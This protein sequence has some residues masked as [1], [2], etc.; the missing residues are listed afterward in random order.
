MEQKFLVCE[1]CGNM[2]AMMKDAG[3]PIV[4][5]GEKMKELV[6][7][8]TDGAAE[9]HVP[10]SRVEGNEVTVCVGSTEHPMLPEHSIE[11]AALQTKEGAQ[12]KTMQPGGRPEVR[13]ALC[14]T[15]EVQAVYAYCNLHGLWKA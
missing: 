6:P 7:G 10:V 11:W 3:V 1:H 12:Y 13:F 4:C 5:C 2:V 14:D 9:K 8:T 15:D